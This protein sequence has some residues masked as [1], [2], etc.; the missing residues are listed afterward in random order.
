MERYYQ[1][2]RRSKLRLCH[3]RMLQLH[4]PEATATGG[5]TMTHSRWQYHSCALKWN[6]R[7]TQ[8]SHL[9]RAQLILWCYVLSHGQ[10]IL[11]LASS[12][13]PPTNP[14]TLHP[15]WVLN[16]G[17]KFHQ[18]CSPG[19]QLTDKYQTPQTLGKEMP[20]SANNQCNHATVHMPYCG[21]LQWGRVILGMPSHPQKNQKYQ[22][23]SH[24][25]DL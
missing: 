6:H 18:T 7:G 16:L 11:P 13:P 10:S 20:I 23:A 15:S 24:Y 22:L 14:P 2:T 9:R 8:L 1:R 25:C 5:L 4:P 3:E 17:R 19:T 12:L 21:V